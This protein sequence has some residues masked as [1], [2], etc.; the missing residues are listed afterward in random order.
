MQ[1]AVEEAASVDRQSLLHRAEAAAKSAA[2]RHSEMCGGA[3]RCTF[4]GQPRGEALDALSLTDIETDTQAWRI[5]RWVD[6]I[7]LAYGWG[8]FGEDSIIPTGSDNIVVGLKE[9]EQQGVPLPAL[10]IFA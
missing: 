8:M 3:V 7:R 10:G 1:W 2:L 6:R 9:A 4:L 5:P